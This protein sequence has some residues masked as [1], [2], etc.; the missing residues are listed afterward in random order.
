VHQ[1]KI[2]VVSLQRFQ[3]LLDGTRE[4]GGPKVL[5]RDFGRDEDFGTWNAA[6]TNRF[7]DDMLGSIFARG[8]D[9]AISRCQRGEHAVGRE[10]A[11]EG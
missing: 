4:V 11:G 8:I 6:R 10:A 7:A 2:D 5:V 3:A 1:Q 9:M